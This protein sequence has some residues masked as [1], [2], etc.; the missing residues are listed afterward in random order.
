MMILVR[1]IGKSMQ[2]QIRICLVHDW[3]RIAAAIVLSVVAVASL[4][5][6]LN[7]SR[8]QLNDARLPISSALFFSDRSDLNCSDLNRSQRTAMTV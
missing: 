8:I 1:C 3:F 6:F 5:E 4:L 7:E 2:S